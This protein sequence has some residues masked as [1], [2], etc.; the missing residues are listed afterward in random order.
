MRGTSEDVQAMT[1]DLRIIPVMRGT[2]FHEIRC[3]VEDGII[4]VMRGTLNDKL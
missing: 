4:P 1:E 2:F 3:L